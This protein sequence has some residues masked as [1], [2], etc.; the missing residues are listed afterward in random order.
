M[1][2]NET[3]KEPGA[4]WQNV[5]IEVAAAKAAQEPERS[6][7]TDFVGGTTAE[8]NKRWLHSLKPQ[9][10][11]G[12]CRCGRTTTRTIAYAAEQISGRNWGLRVTHECQL[13]GTAREVRKIKAALE[14]PDLDADVRARYEQFIAEHSDAA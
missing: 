10:A 4:G 3:L 12:R 9:P 11:E 13:C 8:E 14:R 5:D 2:D 1:P 6:D 7:A